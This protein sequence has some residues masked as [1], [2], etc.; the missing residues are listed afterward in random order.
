MKTTLLEAIGIMAPK[1]GKKLPRD[2][3]AMIKNVNRYR[4]MLY[5]MFNEICLFDDY[6]VC[7][8]V[9]CFRLNCS[10][11]ACDQYYGFVIPHDMDGLMGVWQNNA[12]MTLPS[13]F[14]ELHTSKHT[15]AD[16]D[17][18]AIPVNGDFPTQGEMTKASRLTM[19]GP[20]PRDAGKEVTLQVVD[21]DGIQRTLKFTLD[22][23]QHVFVDL[24]VC[25]II[26]VVLPADRCGNVE[27]WQQ[28]GEVL[29]SE[30]AHTSPQV[31]CFRRYK[32]SKSCPSKCVLV[33]G[34]RK[35]VPVCNDED[36]VE[37][38]GIVLLEAAAVYLR[39]NSSVDAE[40]KQLARIAKSEMIDS[41][42]GTLARKRGRNVEDGPPVM[43]PARRVRSSKLRGYDRR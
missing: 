24:V 38:G 26:S 34:T 35:Y 22:N 19:F 29:L 40:Q 23:T 3:K 10:G 28:D 31:P 41:L 16:N 36:I 2:R 42:N 14:H 7:L 27:L 9:Q 33:Q 21:S 6:E 1:M 30:Y 4:N 32:L 20:D 15:K 39:Y 17:L 13:R 43:K 18:E 25:R 37:I 12:S 8:P 11:C 5:T